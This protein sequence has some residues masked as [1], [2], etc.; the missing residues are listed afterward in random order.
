LICA[1][2]KGS[3]HIKDSPFV[4]IIINIFAKRNRQSYYRGAAGLI[5]STDNYT[6]SYTTHMNQKPRRV[7]ETTRAK[8]Q[9]YL[10]GVFA[11]AT[12]SGRNNEDSDS[13]A[14]SDNDE[15]ADDRWFSG[16]NSR[17]ADIY[18]YLFY[19]FHTYAV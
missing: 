1:V 15:N 9:S 6:C 8:E 4:I 19:P 11:E 2:L 16:F 3:L 17:I 12:I 13:A 5:T 18:S 14:E 7:R 10:K